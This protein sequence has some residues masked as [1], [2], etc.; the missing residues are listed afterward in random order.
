MSMYTWKV[1]KNNRFAGHVESM[2]MMDAYFRAVEIFG[3]NIYLERVV[4]A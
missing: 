2:S 3:G 4:S 1:W